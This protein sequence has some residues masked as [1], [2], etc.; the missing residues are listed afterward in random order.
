MTVPA[1][2]EAT[3]RFESSVCTLRKWE[4]SF[5]SLRR[6][7]RDRRRDGHVAARVLKREGTEVPQG[8]LPSLGT[9]TSRACGSL[10]GAVLHVAT[11]LV[12]PLVCTPE[13]PGATPPPAL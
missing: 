6:V 11:C 3:P 5:L 7:L 8:P 12:T 4:H 2:Q 9:P 10:V 13:L 1:L